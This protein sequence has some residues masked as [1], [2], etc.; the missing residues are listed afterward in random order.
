MGELRTVH[1]LNQFFGGIG[2]ED[3]A[4][5]GPTVREG[6]V[7]PG[8][9]LERALEGQGGIVSTIICGDNFASQQIDRLGEDAL[10]AL[11]EAGADLLVAG[12]AFNAGRYG[13]AC[14]FLCQKAQDVLGV[15][16]VSGMHPENPGVD[17]YR[18]RVSIVRTGE[19]A[20]RMA[21]D[22]ARMARLGMRLARGER[23]GPA[24]EEGYLPTGVR[25][26]R[27]ESATAAE[28]AVAM[29]V[30][31]LRGEPYVTEVPVPTF[32]PVA[33][34]P[35]LA[36]LQRAYLAVITTG[37]VVP[38]GNPDRLEVG[39]STRWGRYAIAG[40]DAL[41]P[42]RF[43]SIHRGYDTASANEDPNRVVPLDALR[44]L[45]RE[46]A[47]GRLHDFYYVTSGQGTYVQHA[48]RMAREIGDELHAAGVQGVLLVAT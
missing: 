41:T 10:K 40:L 3:K 30:A 19:S 17:L 22:L 24:D 16:T 11:K 47:F 46:G 5:I 9:L 34:P 4:D 27:I 38:V 29:L 18:R 15:A 33:P 6:A 48:V 12:P 32:E 31:K 13:I 2:G 35:P 23:L 43:F 26:N 14:G 21:D 8:L 1:Y 39:N 7:G 20:A 37:G 45:E 36:G 28:R 42:D 44:A 25:R